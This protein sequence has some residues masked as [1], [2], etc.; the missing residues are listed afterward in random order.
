MPIQR[1]VL[2]SMKDIKT[3]AG[4]GDQTFYPHKAFMKISCLEMERAHR[5]R[6]R[7]SA[8]LRIKAINDRLS[9]IDREK[10]VLLDRINIANTMQ[11]SEKE[12]PEPDNTLDKKTTNTNSRGLVLRY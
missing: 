2:R 4:S 7:E 5:V 10:N 8:R 9:E 11:A 6:E 1:K 12:H 3:H